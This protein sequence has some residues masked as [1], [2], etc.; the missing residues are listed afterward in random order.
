MPPGDLTHLIESADRAEP[1]AAD[2]LLSAICKELRE[3]AAAELAKE[4][5]ALTLQPTALVNEA[6]LRLLAPPRARSKHPDAESTGNGPNSAPGPSPAPSPHLP[7]FRN[8]R[9]LFGIFA[10]AMREVL[11]DE[12]RRRN[13]AKRNRGKRPAA[14]NGIQIPYDADGLA[15]VLHLDELLPRLH[16][17][18]A[19]AAE[20]AQ[21]RV[22]GGYSL[23]AIAHALDLGAT[24]VQRDWVFARTWMK[25]ELMSRPDHA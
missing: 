15:D 13:A 23:S 1:G 3:I 9:R 8:R 21:L 16:A 12:A 17:L 18:D 22:F 4:S 5:N 2:R 10:R 20:V 6:V 11:V 25:R 14:L 7:A 19:R 24:T